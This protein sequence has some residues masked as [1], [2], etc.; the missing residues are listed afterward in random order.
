[1][2]SFAT[3]ACPRKLGKPPGKR[4]WRG[5]MCRV[6][7]ANEG[8]NHAPSSV[9]IVFYPRVVSRCLLPIER[10][11]EE[12]SAAP[13]ASASAVFYQHSKRIPNSNH[14]SELHMCSVWGMHLH[15]YVLSDAMWSSTQLVALHVHSNCVNTST[16]APL[17]CSLISTTGGT[18][19]LCH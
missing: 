17:Q 5:V 10:P 3:S 16:K 4:S 13:V 9:T 18:Y 8:G 2:R 14:R 19:F 6:T 15:S 7:T 12:D 1:M 11:S